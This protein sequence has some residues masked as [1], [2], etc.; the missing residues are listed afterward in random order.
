VS[1]SLVLYMVVG[2]IPGAYIGARLNLR[3]AE[4]VL[5]ILFG[6]LLGAFGLLFIVNEI[7]SITSKK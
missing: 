7:I 4:R 3:T 5:Y 2:A 1:W 6:A